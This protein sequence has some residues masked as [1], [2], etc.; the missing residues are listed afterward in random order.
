MILGEEFELGEETDDTRLHFSLTQFFTTKRLISIPG[1]GAADLMEGTPVRGA[2]KLGKNIQY[3][4]G[5]DFS[6]I[7]T[8]NRLLNLHVPV[9]ATV[10]RMLIKMKKDTTAAM[11]W[12]LTKVPKPTKDLFASGGKRERTDTADVVATPATAAKC[13]TP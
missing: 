3:L 11:V 4:S 7:V 1:V 6:Q 10:Q 13:Q 9:S 5:A 8:N 2:M 12:D